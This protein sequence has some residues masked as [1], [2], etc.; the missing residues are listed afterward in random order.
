MLKLQSFADLFVGSSLIALCVKC[1]ELEFAKKLFFGWPH[2]SVTSWNALLKGYAHVSDEKKVVSPYWKLTDLETRRNK[3][4]LSIVL[5]FCSRSGDARHGGVV[6]SLVIKIGLNIH[7]YLGCALVGK[8]SKSGL[9]EDAYK[10]FARIK[11]R[12][13]AVWSVMISSFDNQG[14]G[15][16]VVELFRNMNHVGV[17]PNQFTLSTIASVASLIA[18]E[19]FSAR[20]HAFILKSGF[21]MD[22]ILGNIVLNMYI[23]SGNVQD[24]CM[25]LNELADRDTISWIALL[26]GFHNGPHCEEVNVV[27]DDELAVMLE[28][29]VAVGAVARCVGSLDSFACVGDDKV[30]VG[31]EE[32]LEVAIY[33]VLA[34]GD[35]FTAIKDVVGERD[36]EG[37]E[38]KEEE[39]MRDWG[40]DIAI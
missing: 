28:A 31:F 35:D 12:F 4:T 29:E 5:K 16:E 38:E 25:V 14:V 39:K 3:L 23:K 7:E 6:H 13:I 22:N 32:E 18:S 36:G 33:E 8:Y 20:I 10:I 15:V 9:V 11:A 40:R 24:G 26:P 27:A 1:G 17:K 30:A 19:K 37:R 2:L 21:S 34:G